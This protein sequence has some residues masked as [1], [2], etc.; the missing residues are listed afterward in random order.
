MAIS[1]WIKHVLRKFRRVVIVASGVAALI[2]FV[3]FDS[4]SLMMRIQNH[5]DKAFLSEDNQQLQEEIDR[6]EAKLSKPL[7][8]AEVER[9]AREDYHMSKEDETV[10][11]LVKQ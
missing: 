7:T 3:F 11:P 4:Y 6:L 2:W 8:D 10:Y 1:D 5:R 9:V